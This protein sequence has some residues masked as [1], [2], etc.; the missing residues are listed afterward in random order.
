MSPPHGRHAPLRPRESAAGSGSAGGWRHTR[1]HDPR[2]H[3][4]ARA[5]AHSLASAARADAFAFPA[6]LAETLMCKLGSRQRRRAYRLGDADAPF[7][8]AAADLSEIDEEVRR[9]SSKRRCACRPRAPRHMPTAIAEPRVEEE[10]VR[11]LCVRLG[12][13]AR[14]RAWRANGDRR[15]SLRPASTACRSSVQECGVS[16]VL[17]CGGA[18]T[19]TQL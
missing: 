17:E 12:S 16:C 10:C 5:I 18:G 8:V 15:A 14:V 11:A 3:A 7:A 4:C 9:F 1:A 19:W 6:G 13:A 2:V